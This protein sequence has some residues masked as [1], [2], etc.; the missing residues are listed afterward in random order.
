M[1]PLTDQT[2]HYHPERQLAP[3][4]EWSDS[5]EASEHVVQFYESDSFLINA[6]SNYIA[7]GLGADDACIVIATPSH[8]AG[9]ER[10]LS[11][12][13]VDHRAAH[14]SG[15][16]LMLDAAQTLSK[17]MVGDEPDPKRFAKLM[18]RLI[19]RAGSN[20]R[21]MRAFGEMVALL[22]VEGK[23]GA[24]IRLEEL[25][26]ELQSETTVP[27]SLFCGYAMSSFAEHL[28]SDVFNEICH[29]HSRVLPDE[30]YSALAAPDARLLAISLLQQKAASLEAEIAERKRVEDQLRIANQRLD[31]FIGVA[32]HELRTPLTSSKLSLQL[33]GR[34]LACM[35]KA[36][37]ALPDFPGDLAVEFERLGTLVHRT[38]GQID[39]QQRLIDDMLDLSRIQAG[40]LELRLAARDLGH[41]ALE[42]VEEQRSLHP[43]RDIRVSLPE[44]SDAVVL[45][46]DADRIA[47]VVTNLLSNA[48]K[49]S[50]E[51][52]PVTVRV[53]T[54]GSSASVRVEDSGRGLSPEE[55]EHLWS[56]F[57]RVPTMAV[58][59]GSG[60]GLGLG[61]YIS[62][63]ILELHGGQVGIESVVGQGSTFW[64]TLPL[65]GAA[66]N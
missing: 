59:Y 1:L 66:D 48:L 16:L 39:R 56:R 57:Y 24:A 21:H 26:N 35:A 64:F 38:L 28:R 14:R 29:C 65:P 12:L 49:Y 41:V 22:H 62:K 25:W 42:A 6:L 47:Q 20:V 44:D 11:D 33:A 8:R 43:S 2:P 61:L 55:Q 9:L 30:S 5:G 45:C 60:I 31:D 32:G 19:A 52:Q 4:I 46:I 40:K 10:R 27:F 51:D 50:P 17:F 15:R 7:A 63:T 34:G 13:G 58:Q 37:T 53:A 3:H 23:S 54:D 36:L 18:G